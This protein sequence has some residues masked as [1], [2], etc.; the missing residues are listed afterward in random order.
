MSHVVK[1]ETYDENVNKNIV[2]SEW[3]HYAA[4][5]DWQEGCSGLS[6]KIRWINHICENYEEAMKYIEEKDD[7]WYDQLAVK[8]LEYHELKKS[9]ALLTMEEQL[10]KLKKRKTEMTSKIHYANVKSNFISCRNCESKINS[11]Y[12]TEKVSNNIRLKN[13]CPICKSDLRPQST[14][15]SIKNIEKKIE[16]L[17]KKIKLE[18][19]KIEE[20]EKK[21]ATIKW[22]VK[23]EFHC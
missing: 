9:K 7:G 23:I 4:M 8:Y 2:Q 11:K 21:K 6:K 3:D 12:F 14:L 19:R 18:E 1:H 20:K 16:E 10:E 22:L 15:D 5:E 13:T 17:K